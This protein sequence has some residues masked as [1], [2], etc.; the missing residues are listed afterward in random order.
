MI[1]Q[2]GDG[3]SRVSSRSQDLGNWIDKYQKSDHHIDRLVRT[4]LQYESA[5]GQEFPG[6]TERQLELMVLLKF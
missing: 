2:D 5:T 1:A 3:G 6:E 4:V